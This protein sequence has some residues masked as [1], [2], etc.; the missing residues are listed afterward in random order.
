MKPMPSRQIQTHEEQGTEVRP[1][2]TEPW[3][4]SKSRTARGQNRAG[5]CETATPRHILEIGESLEHAI[6]EL[7]QRDCNGNILE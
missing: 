5:L 6:C 2:E 4:R 7:H 3:R 1:T